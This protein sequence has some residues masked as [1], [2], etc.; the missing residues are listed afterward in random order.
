MEEI[1]RVLI[2]AVAEIVEIVARD[3]VDAVLNGAGK[4]R[5]EGDG[6]KEGG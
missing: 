5:E 2:R 4:L 1:E 3:R 6:R